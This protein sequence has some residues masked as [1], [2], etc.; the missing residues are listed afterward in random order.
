MMNRTTGIILLLFAQA[1]SAMAQE[2][3]V[4]LNFSNAPLAQVLDFYEEVSG[5]SVTVAKAAYPTITMRTEKQFTV[6]ETLSL[7]ESNLAQAGIGLDKTEREVLVTLDASK[8]LGPPAPHV[9]AQP[10]ETNQPAPSHP[11]PEYKG[12]ALQKL[13]SD[14]RLEVIRAGLPPLPLEERE[15]SSEE[16]PGQEAGFDKGLQVT[17]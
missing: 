14:Y 13:L 15:S 3:M 7:I 17:P 4:M 8:R 16:E 9:S 12:E 10:P 1:F 2:K 11:S 6:P 5:L